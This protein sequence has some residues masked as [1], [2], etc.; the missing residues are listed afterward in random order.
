M[1]R[2]ARLAALSVFDIDGAPLERGFAG[3]A[4]APVAVGARLSQDDSAA[5]LVLDL[6]QRSTSAPTPWPR[7]IALSSTCRR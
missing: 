4:G 2:V 1:A 3:D 7:R 5:K 6:S